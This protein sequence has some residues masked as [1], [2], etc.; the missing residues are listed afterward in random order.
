MRDAAELA[1]LLPDVPDVIVMTPTPDERSDS[2]YAQAYGGSVQA[3]LDY[4]ER[5]SGAAPR[6]ILFASSTGVYGQQQGE[7]VDENSSTEPAN[8]TGQRLLEAEQRL[9]NSPYQS[10]IVRFSGI[11]GPGRQRLIQQVVRGQTA[12]ATPLVYSNRIHADDAA[13]VL[14]HLLQQPALDNCYIATDCDPAPIHEVHQW[15]GAELGLD[16]TPGNT[17]SERGSKRCN[18]ARLLST[19]FQFRYP[20]YRQGYLSVLDEFRRQQRSTKEGR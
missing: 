1:R 2:G 17:A 4:L 18:N 12:P 10:C 20:S 3:L 14:A 16:A 11:Y 13:A 9:L 5:S 8:F 6:L 15:L 19:G 7:W